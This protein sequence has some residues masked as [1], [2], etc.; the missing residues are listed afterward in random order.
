MTPIYIFIDGNFHTTEQIM[1][2]DIQNYSPTVMFSGTP[3]ISGRGEYKL[4]N[5]CMH[6]AQSLVFPR[7]K[8]LKLFNTLL[9]P[10]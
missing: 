1:E 10:S 7:C 6:T 2:K 4:N 3:C 9:K 8:C 5:T